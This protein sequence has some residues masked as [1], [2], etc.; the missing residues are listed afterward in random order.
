MKLKIIAFSCSL[1]LINFVYIQ[2]M[3]KSSQSC[4]DPEYVKFLAEA[5]QAGQEQC[6][7]T[8]I[9]AINQKDIPSV[10]AEMESIKT[11][12]PYPFIAAIR[13]GNLKTVQALANFYRPSD[14]AK[15]ALFEATRTKNNDVAHFISNNFKTFFDALNHE[16]RMKEIGIYR[17]YEYENDYEAYLRKYSYKTWDTSDKE[18][19]NFYRNNSLLYA[20]VIF[21]SPDTV[22]FLLKKHKA[23]LLSSKNI[24]LAAAKKPAVVHV[25]NTYIAK[26]EQQMRTKIEQEWTEQE[27][28]SYQIKDRFS[29]VKDYCTIQ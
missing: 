13:D 29:S 20:A 21:D 28:W 11:P 6:A 5:R 27:T 2:A 19:Q 12:N 4:N 15:T 26:R 14:V 24:L 3:N 9:E 22:Q 16:F 8:L 7:K 1:A 25:L 18:I 23:Q 17:C 10:L